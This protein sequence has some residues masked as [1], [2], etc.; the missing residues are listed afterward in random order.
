VP[1]QEKDSM[2][3][4]RDP[5]PRAD[6]VQRSLPFLPAGRDIRHAF[7]AQTAPNF[8]YFYLTYLTGLTTSR[9]KYRCVVIIP[10]TIYVLDSNKRSGGA[11][12]QAV[13]GTMPRQTKLGPVTGRWAKITLVGQA[14]WVHRRFHDQITGADRDAGF[15]RRP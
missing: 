4:D 6:L 14:H 8:A 10:D 7:I 11:Q 5:A 1:V 13:A 12:P 2:N 3:A 9:T 15:G